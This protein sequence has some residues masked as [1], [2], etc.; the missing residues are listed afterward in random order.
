MPPVAADWGAF[1]GLQHGSSI[2][3]TLTLSM[4]IHLLT[5]TQ[6]GLSAS[7]HGWPCPLLAVVVGLGCGV[8]ALPAGHFR[9]VRSRHSSGCRLQHVCSAVG[10]GRG[11]A[12]G[13]GPAWVSAGMREV[14]K[15][16]CLQH[17]GMSR[18]CCAG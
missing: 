6:L 11:Q 8:V 16:V 14:M 3:L 17:E 5:S 2:A 9:Q 18:S 1:P 13:T 12:G 10:G 4:I 15:A 7:T